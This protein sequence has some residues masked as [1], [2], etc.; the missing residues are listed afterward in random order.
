M[1]VLVTAHEEKCFVH[2]ERPATVSEDDRQL[3]KI[4]AHI[5]A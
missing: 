2:P 5:V 3:R 1:H 4:N